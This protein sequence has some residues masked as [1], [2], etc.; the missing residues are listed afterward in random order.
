MKNKQ[1]DVIVVGG[2]P[3]GM[4]AAGRAAEL[5]VR[6]LLL[7]K[8]DRLGKKLSWTGGGRCN[9]TNAVFDDQLFLNNFPQAKQ[10]LFSP[11]SQ[12]GVQD[13]FDF[14]EKLGLPLV[15]ED[16]ARAFPKSESAQD[17]CDVLEKYMKNGGVTIE[18]GAS[19]ESLLVSGSR[20]EGVKTAAGEFRSKSIVFA[21]GGL[22]APES[23]STGDGLSML[24]ELGH[25]VQ[26]SDPSLSPL[27]TSSKW[28][29]KLSGMSLDDVELR[30][31]Q[32]E[33]TKHKVRGRVLLTHFGIS[34]PLVINSAQKVKGLLQ[35]SA[36]SAS[37]DL[38]PDHNHASLDAMIL[39]LFEKSSAKT[40]KSILRN[41]IQKKLS[42]TILKFS[43]ITISDTLARDVS[44]EQRKALVHAL[45]DLNFQITGTMGL[46]WSIVADGGVIP[47]E[48]DFKSMQS[49]KIENL[50]IIGDLININRPSGGFSL[51]LCW[52]M[53][54]VAG[55]HMAQDCTNR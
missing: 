54:W 15:V 43:Q 18:L 29:H 8:N 1:Y 19:V 40:V 33:K 37:I 38:F 31:K 13:T 42:D 22:A 16:R 11:F 3:A 51:Q 24:E 25:T 39:D 47:E 45:K 30:F 28:V 55:S 41:L 5:G 32:G 53:G 35:E 20:I 14:F 50:Y 12:F 49:N 27:K 4:M 52:T 46:D 17:V 26:A 9:I 34:G 48:I 6:V 2:G 36:V 7:E 23:G 44:K 21:T 10:F